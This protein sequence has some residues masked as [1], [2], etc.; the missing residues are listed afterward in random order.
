MSE[1]SPTISQN[2]VRA[3]KELHQAKRN[4]GKAWRVIEGAKLQ[5]KRT[6]K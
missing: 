6:S 2:I 3:E 5:L 4:M 1:R